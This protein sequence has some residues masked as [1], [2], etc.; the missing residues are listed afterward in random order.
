MPGQDYSITANLAI[1]CSKCN[2]AKSDGD[3]A[4]LKRLVEWLER[5]EPA[6]RAAVAAARPA[7]PEPAPM[8]ATST[9]PADRAAAAE[10]HLRWVE[11]L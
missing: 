10:A 1:L 8:P 9:D 7:E 4:R 5:V 11:S 3:L 6:A 2:R